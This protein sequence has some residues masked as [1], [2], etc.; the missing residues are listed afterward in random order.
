MT[1]IAGAGAPADAAARARPRARAEHR[2][3]HLRLSRLAA[4]RLR[5]GAVAAQDISRAHDMVFRPGV[6]EDL[7][8]TA[9]WGTQQVSCW[10]GAPRTTASSASGTA[11]GRASTAAATCFQA[12]QRRRHLA[13]TAACWRWPATTTPAKSSTLPHQ[14]EHAL[15][16]R[17]DP[18]STPRACRSILDYGILGF[19]LSRYSGCWVGIKC[20][21]R[22]RRELGLG[23]RSTR[24]HQQVKI[25]DDFEP[26]RR[27]GL[28]IRWPIQPLEQEPACTATRCRRGL[29]F[30]RANK[31][32][33]IVH[34]LGR[35]PQASASWR[36]AR[37]I[38]TCARRSRISASTRRVACRARHPRLQGRHDLAAGAGG[39]RAFAEGLEEILVVEE[40]RSIIEDQLKEQLYNGARPAPA[41]VGNAT[42]R[43]AA[44]A[45]RRRARRRPMVARAIGERLRKGCPTTR[46][47]AA[48]RAWRL[49]RKARGHGAGKRRARTPYFCS[50]C[51]HNTSTACPRAAAPRPASAATTW[52]CGWTARTETSRRWAA[53]APP[54]SGRRPSPRRKHVFQN[55]GDG[56]YFHSGCSRSAPRSPPASTS[57]TR[58]STT[59]PSR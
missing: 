45:G 40:K 7:A 19:A 8:A 1:G 49:E 36:P 48:S 22:Q 51:P 50:G 56:T 44:V 54:G 12:R 34:R 32:D 42:R 52:R 58:S 13:S 38:S 35:A 28:N 5:P 16:A 55:L 25:P 23:R 37:P 17:L 47:A 9:V 2:G 26:C 18:V 39:V 20:D 31:L 24:P 21:H 53:K 6:N 43:R 10:R 46:G 30:A 27:A 4:R 3:L 33:R 41:V 11:R 29:A 59:T 57:P 14:S 15:H